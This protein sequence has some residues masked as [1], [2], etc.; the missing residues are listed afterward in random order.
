MKRTVHPIVYV[1]SSN[2]KG[3]EIVDFIDWNQSVGVLN[4]AA[5]IN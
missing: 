4:A 1:T 3:M 2:T 5:N